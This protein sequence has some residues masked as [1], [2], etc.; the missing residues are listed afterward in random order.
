MVLHCCFV[1]KIL[2]LIWKKESGISFMFLV[3]KNC[4]FIVDLWGD[5][6]IVNTYAVLFILS[7]IISQDDPD[8][9]HSLLPVSVRESHKESSLISYFTWSVM[10]DHPHLTV[11]LVWPNPLVASVICYYMENYSYDERNLALSKKTEIDGHSLF[12]VLF[13]Y[14]D[15]QGNVFSYW[16]RP[17]PVF[18]PLLE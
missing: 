10:A 8:P 18:C 1:K 13:Q 16:L 15:K 17:G 12:L 4:T 11:T 3:N 9:I 7:D 6:S 5:C 2:S 14:M